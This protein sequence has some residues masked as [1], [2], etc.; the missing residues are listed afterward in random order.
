MDP[1]YGARYR[2]LYQRHWWWRAREAVVTREL[3]RLA[4]SNGWSRAL[5]VG[6]GDGLLFPVLERCAGDVEGIEPDHGLVGA[7]RAG[8]RIHLRPFDESFQ[9]GHRYG[10]IL[11]L[12]VLEHMEDPEAAVAHAAELLEPGGVVLVTVPAWMHLWT[13]HDELNHHVTRYDASRLRT[14]L[15]TALEVEHIRYFFRWVHKAKLAQKAWE[16]VT[17][18][19]PSPPSLPPAPLNA[20][21]YGVSRAEETLLGRIPLPMGSSLLAVGRK[22]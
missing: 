1:A 7:D 18:P 11:F 8:G 3:E 2:E 4:P 13:T 12:D 10:L 15:E 20:L 22:A 14:L 16:A 6:C 5:D 21:L 19:E 9:P 17:R